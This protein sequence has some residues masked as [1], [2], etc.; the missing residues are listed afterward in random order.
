[1]FFSLHH[2][3]SYNNVGIYKQFINNQPS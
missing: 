2:T 3:L 1:M